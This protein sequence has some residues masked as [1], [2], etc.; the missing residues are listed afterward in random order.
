MEDLGEPAVNIRIGVGLRG[1]SKESFVEIDG[2]KLEG[3]SRLRLEMAA[4]V[5]STL[6]LEMTDKSM[7]EG[8]L[9]PSGIQIVQLGLI[10]CSTQSLIA[11]LKSRG[12]L[13]DPGSSIPFGEDGL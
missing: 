6:T 7:V 8:Q 12:V 11:E 9:L 10:G 5:I 2:V 1:R 3:V 4:E 13:P